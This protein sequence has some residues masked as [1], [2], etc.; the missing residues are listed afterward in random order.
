MK[1]KTVCLMLGAAFVLPPAVVHAQSSD[2]QYCQVL[3]ERYTTY[4]NDPNSRRPAPAN[5]AVQEAIA[6]CKG[7]SPAAGIPTLEKALTNAGFTL[8]SRG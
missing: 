8:P 1:I 2:A 6:Q 5:A 3:A 4:V 7:S